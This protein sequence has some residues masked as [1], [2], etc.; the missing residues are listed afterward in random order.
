[1]FA[2]NVRWEE[3]AIANVLDTKFSC[4][5]VPIPSENA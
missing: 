4:M 3:M 1:M 2:A 5:G